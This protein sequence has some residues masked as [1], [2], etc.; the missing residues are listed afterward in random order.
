MLVAQ[1]HLKEQEK[2]FEELIRWHTLGSGDRY[3][4]V[5]KSSSGDQALSLNVSRSGRRL[6]VEIDRCE[7]I[8]PDGYYIDISDSQWGRIRVEAEV[9][10]GPVPVYISVDPG[11]K[12]AV[13]NPDPA[14]EIPRL[15]YMSPVYS[16]HLGQKPNRPSGHFLQIAELNTSGGDV[17]QSPGYYPP[18]VT[19]YADDR[20]NQKVTE[21]KNRLEKL[22]LLS[23]QAYMA[24]SADTEL[25]SAGTA[26]QASFKETIGQFVH[27]LAA[28]HDELVAGR[29]A[30]HPQYLV[31]FFKRL[32]RVFSTLLNLHPGL[33]DYVNEKYFMKV[34]A[35]E[36]GRYMSAIDDFLL[37]EYDH[38]NLGGHLAV[39]DGLFGTLRE[40]LGL[41]AQVKKDQLGAQAVATDTLTYSGVTYRLADYSGVR[42]EKVG[43]LYYLQVT[44]SKPRPMSDAVVLMAKDL[45][46]MQIWANMQLRLG[47]NE[48]RGLGE[49]D[50][51]TADTVTFGNKVAL[52]AED[53]MKSSMVKQIT[54]IFRGAG[55][56]EKLSKLGKTDLIVYAL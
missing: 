5:R 55:Q 46:S 19:L 37:S 11:H 10:E 40:I 41:F 30:A 23:S 33:K 50:P 35:S 7:A 9:P 22:I 1:Q 28:S 44:I 4:L 8:T 16:L 54:L 39:I 32:F 31:I 45:F 3:G 48:A 25:A 49:T 51:I 43:E 2:Y 53:M 14:E 24:I 18:C 12:N 47:L 34:A 26:L 27:H 36:I 52:R 38:N 21:Y 29:N 42:L 6:T 20:L 15:P 17:V 56:A 13:G